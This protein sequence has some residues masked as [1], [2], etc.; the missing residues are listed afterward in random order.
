MNLP[1]SNLS[2]K[3]SFS[4]R[5][6]AEEGLSDGGDLSVTL[7]ACDELLRRD[8][9][10][11]LAWRWRG[12]ALKQSGLYSLSALSFTQVLEISGGSDPY[13]F[14]W[15]GS[16]LHLAGQNESALNDCTEAVR[17]GRFP[18]NRGVAHRYYDER[19]HLL[20]K[21]GR[22][23]DAI[24]DIQKAIQLV[25]DD[26]KSMW[27]LIE[28]NEA[29]NFIFYF[30]ETR[31]NWLMEIH[32]KSPRMALNSLNLVLN[33][34]ENGSSFLWQGSPIPGNWEPLS[35]ELSDDPEDRDED[36]DD[37]D[38]D[39]E[40][41]EEKK[42]KEEIEKLRQR[43]NWMNFAELFLNFSENDSRCFLDVFFVAP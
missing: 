23:V 19:S 4:L 6:E 39:D 3:S 31:A 35:E 25:L 36:E 11:V 16:S 40:G 34:V 15:R 1:T 33:L 17:R 38:E 21:I 26:F 5:Q 32:P 8:P 30:S 27:S 12:I 24:R 9:T 29:L 18:S 20:F 10:L 2:S 13:D 43:R 7:R 41:N 22:R 14:L 37:E 28:R 42:E